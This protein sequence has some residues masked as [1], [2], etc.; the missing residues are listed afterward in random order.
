MA[1]TDTVADVQGRA[2]TA[3]PVWWVFAREAAGI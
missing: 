3:E 2:A 1:Q